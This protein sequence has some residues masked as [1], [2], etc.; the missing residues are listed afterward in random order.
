MRIRTYA[1]IS[2]IGYVLPD[3]QP[4]THY[5]EIW[6]PFDCHKKKGVEPRQDRDW[7]YFDIWRR[8]G[9]SLQKFV[10]SN[11]SLLFSN[12]KAIPGKNIP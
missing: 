7:K 5:A 10:E 8:G 6:N 2:S 12:L 9:T 11:L 1:Y 4:C 3:T